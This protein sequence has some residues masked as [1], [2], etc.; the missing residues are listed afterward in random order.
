[1]NTSKEQQRLLA[2]LAVLLG[3]LLNL[4]SSGTPDV[5]SMGANVLAFALFLVAV[6][7]LLK[8]QLPRLKGYWTLAAVLL[9]A[10]GV[11]WLIY[12]T[13]YL[14]DPLFAALPAPYGWVLFGLLGFVAASGG[15]A[16]V[17]KLLRREALPGADPPTEPPADRPGQ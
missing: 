1:M 5:A 15:H 11:A 7:G 8:R 3:P 10:Q 2:M 16:W 14:T 4:L 12:V 17:E 6:T 9:V 13:N